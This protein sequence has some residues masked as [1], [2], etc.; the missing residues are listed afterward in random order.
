MS[1]EI[2]SAVAD[3]PEKCDPGFL[4]KL[5]REARRCRYRAD[6]WHP[7]EP[8]LLD[9]LVRRAA[10]DRKCVA[11]ERDGVLEEHRPDHLVDGIVPAD[12]L[13]WSPARGVERE[14]AGGMHTSALL[15][16]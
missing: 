3:K 1:V 7:R 15:R 2:E 6:D 14:Q 9:D 5:D 8:R 12:I 13:G 11:T 4:R 10:A 16:E